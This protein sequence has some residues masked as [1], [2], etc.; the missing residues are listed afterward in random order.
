MGRGWGWSDDE[1][2]DD[3]EVKEIVEDRTKDASKGSGP[4]EEGW[5]E[6]D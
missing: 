5:D 6:D 4:D 3:A 2:P 1:L